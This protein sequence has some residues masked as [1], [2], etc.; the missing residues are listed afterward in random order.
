MRFAM[1]I[2][3][4]DE[5]RSISRNAKQIIATLEATERHRSGIGITTHSLQQRLWLLHRGLKSELRRVFR[6]TMNDVRHWP[7]PKD[8][9]LRN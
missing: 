5:L 2:P 3:E 8:S 4:L 6:P 1:A 9:P 7:T